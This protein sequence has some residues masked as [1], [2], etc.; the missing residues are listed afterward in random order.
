MDPATATLITTLGESFLSSIF[1][2]ATPQL[3]QAQ[4]AAILEQKRQQ[5]AAT[6]RAWLIGGGLAAAALVAYLVISRK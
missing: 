1:T 5:E 6:Q 2:P 3:S 4:I